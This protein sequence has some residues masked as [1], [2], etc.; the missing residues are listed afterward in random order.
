MVSSSMPVAVLRTYAAQ[1]ERAGGVLA[2]R[3]T[4]GGMAKVAPMAKL[5]AQVLRIDAG[6]EGPACAMHDV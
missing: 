6:C 2:F 1:L 5:A 4:P 3:G